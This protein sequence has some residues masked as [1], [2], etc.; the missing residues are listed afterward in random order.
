MKQII[1]IISLFL[2][3]TPLSS[4]AQLVVSNSS[5]WV[6]SCY[7]EIEG[8]HSRQRNG[9]SEIPKFRSLNELTRYF[10]IRNYKSGWFFST[11]NGS[12]YVKTEDSN[13]GIKD[14]GRV[15]NIYRH[16]CAI[17]DPYGYDPYDLGWSNKC[18]IVIFVEPYQSLNNQSV[19]VAVVLKS[20]SGCSN[21]YG[22]WD[23]FYF[24]K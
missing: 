13:V 7:L 8:F 17:K 18:Y 14:N 1:K 16:K 10:G 5:D 24:Y 19:V 4:K 2:I 12:C 9:I 15:S 22:E 3:L 21:F 6:K 11:S 20:D 23:A